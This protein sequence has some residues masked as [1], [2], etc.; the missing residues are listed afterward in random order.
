MMGHGSHDEFTVAKNGGGVCAS[1]EFQK[2]CNSLKTC[3]KKSHREF[4]TRLEN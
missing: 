2:L 3:K 4:V 1:S